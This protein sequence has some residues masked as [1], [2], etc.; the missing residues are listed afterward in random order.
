MIQQYREDL[1][2]S[3]PLFR[4]ER[5]GSEKQESQTMFLK[6][7]EEAC[8]H[9]LK[10]VYLEPPQP[11]DTRQ[12]LSKHPSNRFRTLAES[13]HGLLGQNWNSGSQSGSAA[14]ARLSLTLFDPQA[15]TVPQ[16]GDVPNGGGTMFE[17]LL[18]VCERGIDWK[19]AKVWIVTSK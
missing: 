7:I 14:E 18:P 1:G 4:R 9:L 16:Q 13:V 15:D 11:S 12:T 6:V 5:A 8:Q 3:I 2:V 10:M 17:I 19:V